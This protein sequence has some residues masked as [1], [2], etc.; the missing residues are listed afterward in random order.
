M[1]YYKD[2]NDKVY[3]FNDIQVENG[4]ADDYIPIQADEVVK[5]NITTYTDKELAE[6]EYNWAKT[7]LENADIGLNKVLDGT[8]TFTTETQWRGYRRALR[9]YVT[10]S[11]GAYSVVDLTG[12]TY[13]INDIE[14]NVTLDSDT[15]R[16]LSPTITNNS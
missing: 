11:D 13:T 10:V 16:P 8:D 12:V 2:K 9:A 14:Y 3:G 1:N 5:L 15:G 6:I 7:E 4:K